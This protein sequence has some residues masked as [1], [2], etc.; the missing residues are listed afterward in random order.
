MS[1]K[2]GDRVGAILKADKDSVHLLGYGVYDGPQ[3]V[4]EELALRPG[5]INP[6]LTLDNGN[7]VW[8]FQCWWGGEA[9]VLKQ[10]AGRTV[11]HANVKD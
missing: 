11:I 9:E 5:Q 3:K 4:P 1:A 6:R 7:V 10:I 8:G 2:I